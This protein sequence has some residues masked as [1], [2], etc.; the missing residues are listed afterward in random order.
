MLVVRSTSL[1]S[2]VFDPV[3]LKYSGRPSTVAATQMAT[4]WFPVLFIEQSLIGLQKG[5]KLDLT[6]YYQDGAL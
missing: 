5:F 3:A 4:H 2:T 6:F 1:N